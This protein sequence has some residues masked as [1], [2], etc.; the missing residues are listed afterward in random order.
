LDLPELVASH[1]GVRWQ[2]AAAAPW[3]IASIADYLV[4][5]VADETT[6]R[7]SA[8]ELEVLGSHQGAIELLLVPPR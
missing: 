7:A 1:G 2:T 6:R 3:L 5:V 8:T 4:A